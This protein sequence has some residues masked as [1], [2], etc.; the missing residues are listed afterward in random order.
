M[1]QTFKFKL[2]KKIDFETALK[3]MKILI[4]VIKTIK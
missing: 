4:N 1:K 3:S 2:N